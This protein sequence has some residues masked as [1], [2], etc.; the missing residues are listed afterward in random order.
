MCK[1]E[2]ESTITK[3]GKEDGNDKYGAASG[4]DQRQRDKTELVS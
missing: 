2:E 4:D 3:R 1:V